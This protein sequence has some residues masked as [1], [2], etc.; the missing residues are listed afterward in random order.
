MG[1]ARARGRGA[2]RFVVWGLGFGVQGLGLRGLSFRFRV[3]GF[4]SRSY[5]T[6]PRVS[7]TFQRGWARALMRDGAR[8]HAVVRGVT[9][10]G[11]PDIAQWFSISHTM[12]L[13]RLDRNGLSL[14]T[15]YHKCPSDARRHA[16]V[17]GATPRGSTVQGCLAHKKPPP[18]RS[19]Q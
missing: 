19:L 7:S 3:S 12:K 2:F 1:W 16:A 8:R 9:L 15:Q 11:S 10:R 13:F 17:R 18:P 14:A 6:R 5:R 4:G